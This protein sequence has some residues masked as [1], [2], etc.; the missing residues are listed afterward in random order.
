MAGFQTGQTAVATRDPPTPPARV[1][2]HMPGRVRFRVV[3]RR[4]DGAFFAR[5]G[6]ALRTQAGV[7]AVTTDARTGSVLVVH[8]LDTA[9]VVA[10]AAAQGLFHVAGAPGRRDPTAPALS[11]ASA[12]FAALGSYQLVRGRLAGTALENFWNAYGAYAVLGQPWAGAALL[13]VGLYQLARGRVLG[14]AS[15]LFFYALNARYLARTGD[16]QAAG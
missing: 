5:V 8:A 1:A 10:L 13:G 4:G 7:S 2:H 6:A 16:P 9:A 14:P 15:S 12:G 3:A 11:A